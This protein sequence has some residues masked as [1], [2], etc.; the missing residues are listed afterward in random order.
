[1]D[2][3]VKGRQYQDSE[4]GTPGGDWD[5]VAQN[6]QGGKWHI[7]VPVEVK[8][9][10]WTIEE[11]QVT[12]GFWTY[13]G[14]YKPERI[15]DEQGQ[16]VWVFQ[17]QLP[18]G[19]TAFSELPDIFKK[20]LLTY[21]ASAGGGKK[22]EK[23]VAPNKKSKSKIL[24]LLKRVPFPRHL[25]RR[26]DVSIEYAG[27]DPLPTDQISLGRFFVSDILGEEVSQFGMKLFSTHP[28]QGN[29]DVVLKFESLSIPA[30]VLHCREVPWTS[31]IITLHPFRYRLEV[32]FVQRSG[33]GGHEELIDYSKELLKLLS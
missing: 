19:Y 16:S 17:D 7:Y 25:L 11:L 20:Y 4:F 14:Q 2:Q 3:S 27:V 18:K 22:K 23:V 30:R 10:Q 33:T 1:M 24:T 26:L 6:P 13:S 28:I 8:R 21:V 32:I 15:Q 5:F 31:R 12:E 9:G 29:R